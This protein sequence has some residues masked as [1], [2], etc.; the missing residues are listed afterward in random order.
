MDLAYTHFTLCG[1]KE[2]AMLSPIALFGFNRPDKFIRVVSK[3]S[4]NKVAGDSDLFIF[5][6]A[7]KVEEDVLLVDKVLQIAKSVSGFKTV[8]IISHFSNLGLARSIK[9]GIDHVLE[10][11]ETVIVLED[12]LLVAESFIDYM[13]AG[14]Q[15]FKN[16]RCVASIQGYQYPINQFLDSAV[17]LKG[18]DCWG[19]ATWKDRWKTVDFDTENL[20]CELRKNNLT[21]EF[22]LDGSVPYMQML[23]DQ[24]NKKIDSW[25]IC[26][27]ASMFLQ[28]R[29]SIYPPESLVMN[30]GQDGTGTHRTKN[31][32]FDT[33]IGKW[34]SEIGWPKAVEDQT[35][36]DYLMSYYVKKHKTSKLSFVKDKLLLKKILFLIR[37]KNQRN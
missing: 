31:S 12:D 24:K 30:I 14:L 37:G 23:D 13:N 5:L 19:W 4:K 29:V 8:Q 2:V 9:Y 1:G 28:N 33:K 34:N 17:A 16:E 21:F 7:P 15:Y 22:D 32:M 25:A 6:D 27:H 35:Y 36:R 20:Q 11:H 18:A 3:L 10:Q 26:W